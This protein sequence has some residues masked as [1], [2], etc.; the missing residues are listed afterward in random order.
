VEET[1]GVVGI[2][3]AF[4]PQLSVEEVHTTLQNGEAITVLD[5]REDWEWDQGHVG[6]ALHMQMNDVPNRRHE[7]EGASKIVV[8]CHLGQ[9]SAMITQYLLTQGLQNVYNMA[10]GMDSWTRHG[11]E[12]V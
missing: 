12:V 5:V 10:G 9:R 7:L 6:G 3:Q 2:D 11:Y 8:V 4:L 1:I